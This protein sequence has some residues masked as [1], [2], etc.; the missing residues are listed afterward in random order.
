MT[1]MRW[2]IGAVLMV[3]AVGACGG[4]GQA[5]PAPTPAELAARP[6]SQYTLLPGDVIRLR[7]W[8]EPDL[9]GEFPVAEDGTVTFPKIG[10]VKA[11]DF[12]PVALEE[13]VLERYGHYLRNPSIEIV[14]LRRINILGA[15][16]AP[17]LYPVDPTMT[18]RDAVAMAGGVTPNGRHDRVELIRG[19]MRLYTEVRGETRITDLGIRSGDQIYVPER[20]WMSRNAGIVATVASTIVSAAVALIIAFRP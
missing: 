6:D 11:T 20:A 19:D 10:A 2:W 3:M 14:P 1:G 16:R 13:T 17:G 4:G 8:R 18:L 5:V 9:S 12:T 15:V 7:I